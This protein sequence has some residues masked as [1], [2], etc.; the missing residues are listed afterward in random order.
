[1]WYIHEY[2]DLDHGLDFAV[3][4][5]RTI[6]Y[7]WDNSDLVMTVSRSVGEHL[8]EH[9]ASED[10]LRYVR[11]SFEIDEYLELGP[12]ADDNSLLTLGAIK[13]SKGQLDALVGFNESTIRD[14]HTL[15]IAGPVTEPWY[16]ERIREFID[17]QG[18]G[19]RVDFIPERVN[20]IEQMRRASTVLVC[21]RNEALGRITLEALAAGRTVVGS[22][23]G[24]TAVLLDESRGVLYDGSTTDLT[25]KLDELGQSVYRLQPVEARQQYVVDN[26]SPERER[27]DFLAAIALAEDHHARSS[28]RR[29]V[30]QMGKT[31]ILDAMH[32]IEIIA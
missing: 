11:Q 26:F 6:R 10:K 9:G 23:G 20:A 21:S 14:T 13:S 25:S 15:T 18:L 32:R 3:G 31:G 27:D 1:M 30:Q 16:A 17:D 2:G 5:D 12:P 19:D 8:L 29:V 24:G 28:S 7:V 4:Y 22:R